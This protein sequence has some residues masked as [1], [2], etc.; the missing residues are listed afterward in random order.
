MNNKKKISFYAFAAIILAIVYLIY[1][2]LCDFILTNIFDLSLQTDN[3]AFVIVVLS[4]GLII[5]PLILMLVNHL[6]KNKKHMLA[7]MFFV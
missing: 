4:Y 7:H 5:L 6:L 3:L 1:F 2:R